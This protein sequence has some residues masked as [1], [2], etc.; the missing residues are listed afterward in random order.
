MKK[1]IILPKILVI[2]LFFISCAK[3]PMNPEVNIE[4]Q[5]KLS[6]TELIKVAQNKL[7]TVS[8]C[9]KDMLKAN[10]NTITSHA[11]DLTFTDGASAIYSNYGDYVD[12][13][14]NSSPGGGGG[15]EELPGPGNE[16][17]SEYPEIIDAETAFLVMSQTYRSGSNGTYLQALL[18]AYSYAISN[19]SIASTPE[20]RMIAIGK[21]IYAL[22]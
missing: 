17:P 22:V 20:Q 16:V 10:Y 19:Y 14:M 18:S 1:L 6:K 5:S 3:A 21:A 2:L 7:G 13:S 15:G 11:G 12:C 9:Y 8:Q 4:N